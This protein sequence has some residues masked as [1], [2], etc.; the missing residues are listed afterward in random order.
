MQISTGNQ[1]GALEIELE[2][3]RVMKIE[4]IDRFIYLGILYSRYSKPMEDF[5]SF[6]LTIILPVHFADY[7]E[8]IKSVK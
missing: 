8:N 3:S 1:Q 6:P 5:S 7:F 4:K 2:K